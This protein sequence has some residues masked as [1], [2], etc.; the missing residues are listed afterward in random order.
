VKVDV[1]DVVQ[2]LTLAAITVIFAMELTW[3]ARC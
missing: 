2:V 1:R 3:L